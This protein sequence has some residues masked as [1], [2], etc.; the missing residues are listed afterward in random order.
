VVDAG[1][2]WGGGEAWYRLV[3]L[4]RLV[5][6]EP[7]PQECDRLNGQVS[8]PPLERYVPL[9]LGKANG[10]R[11]L[12]VTAE[13]MCA[14]LYQPDPAMSDRYPVLKAM[15]QV[16]TRTVPVV[17]L[18]SWARREGVPEVSFLKIDTQ[19]SEL[20][21]LHGAGALLDG[22][23]GMEVEVEF[24]PLYHGQPLF[25]DVDRYRRRRG[26]VLWRLKNLS[27]LG[28]GHTQALRHETKFWYDHLQV[29]VPVGA[30]RLL[31]GDAV[32]LRDYR[33]LR[34]AGHTGRQ[35]LILAALLNA[36]GDNDG[37]CACLHHG[38]AGS[39]G[40]DWA[41]CQLVRRHLPR[42]EASPAAAGCCAGETARDEKP[43]VVAI[44][45]RSSRQRESPCVG[46][47]VSNP[48]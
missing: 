4:A 48:P 12:F 34:P 40:W 37:A 18:A 5:G 21:I 43:G 13:P 22:C 32:Y 42:L 1:A 31:W 23:L 24:A 29:P 27:Q 10:W 25:A 45:T 35:L 41:T 7:D 47:K 30:G 44:E 20:D 15:R 28:E 6:F 14:S 3:P 46:S 36:L 38:L 2:R 39:A 16:S 19:G 11:T 9:G 8:C 26:F 33:E 17:S